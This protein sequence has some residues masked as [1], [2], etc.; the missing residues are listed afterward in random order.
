MHARPQSKETRGSIRR[1]C[2]AQPECLD[3]HVGR[4]TQQ[5]IY[6]D[7]GEAAPPMFGRDTQQNIYMDRRIRAYASLV[8]H[9]TML[10]CVK[11]MAGGCVHINAFLMLVM[12]ITTPSVRSKPRRFRPPPND[13]RPHPPLPRRPRQQL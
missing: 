1:Q 6:M 10:F 7:L 12:A 8:G 3:L 13:R 5:N 11:M 4:E 9:A 2:P